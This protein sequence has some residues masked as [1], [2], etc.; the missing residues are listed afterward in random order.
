MKTTI[1]LLAL[2]VFLGSVSF[3]TAA[4]HQGNQFVLD[5]PTASEMSPYTI[6][7]G[8]EGPFY[9]RQAGGS[10]AADVSFLTFCVEETE[11]FTPGHTYKVG[12]DSSSGIGIQ[13][14]QTNWILSPYTAWLYTSFRDSSL[15]AAWQSIYT[16]NHTTAF[17]MLQYAIWAG[18]TSDGGAVGGATAEQ[19]FGL[20]NS[21]LGAGWSV[22]DLNNA[23]IG[24]GSA[25]FIAW[26]DAKQGL[27]DVWVLNLYDL[28]NGLAQDQLALIPGL[29]NPP[30]PEPATVVIWSMLSLCTCLAV[31]GARKR[32]AA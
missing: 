6:P 32:I 9:M 4:I 12:N 13:S 30:V 5:F 24:P 21:F 27:G 17:N 1:Q 8:T 3:A 22:T 28:N 26:N 2:A 16:V 23:G 7:H 29:R 31:Y 18:M 25:G 11:Y 14:V 15:D 10:P 20:S 19:Q